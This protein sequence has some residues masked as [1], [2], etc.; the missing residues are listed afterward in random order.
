MLVYDIETLRG[1]DEVRGG[2]SNPEAMGFGTGVVYSTKTDT[3]YFYEGLEGK[4]KMTDQLAAGGLLVGF[5]SIRFDNKVLLGNDY[6]GRSQLA[7]DDCDLLLEVVKTKF[8]VESVEEA[9]KKVGQKEVHDGSIGLDGLAEGTLGMHKI[10]HG[11]HA[12]GLIK[13]GRWA[14]VFAYN[15]HDVRL[16]YKLLWFLAVNGFLIDRKRNWIGIGKT[17]HNLIERLKSEI[18]C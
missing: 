8:A 9:E 18:F 6:L 2:W 17:N 12:P 15:L 14:N 4:A 10:G 7:N 16:T 11:A 5:N 3:Y 13:A 1:P